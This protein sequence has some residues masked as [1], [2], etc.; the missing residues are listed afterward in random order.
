MRRL[1]VV[2]YL[3]ACSPSAF[4]PTG[5]SHPEGLFVGQPYPAVLLAGYACRPEE[6]LSLTHRWY[7]TPRVSVLSAEATTLELDS[8]LAL[9]LEVA[10]RANWDATQGPDH[11]RAGRFFVTDALAAHAFEPLVTDDAQSPTIVAEG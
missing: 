6:Y 10:R 3:A 2:G 5:Y 1:W 9:L 8:E 4:G 11:L 7:Q